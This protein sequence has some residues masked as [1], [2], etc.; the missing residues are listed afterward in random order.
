MAASQGSSLAPQDAADGSGTFWLASTAIASFIALFLYVT[1]T[2]TSKAS[3]ALRDPIPHVFNTLQFMFNNHKFMQRVQVALQ[4]RNLVCFFLGPKTVYLLSGPQAVKAMFS[5]ELVHKVTNQEQ[6]TRYALPTLYKM[7]SQEVQRWEDDKSGVTK[8]P[9]RGTEDTPTR[10]RLWYMYEHIYSEY[11]GRPQYMKPLVKMFSRNLSRALE[12]YPTGEWTT[13]SVRKI[14][15]HEVTESA[16]SALLG[17]D[18]IESSPDFV[19]RFWEFDKHVFALVLG[20]PKWINS[21][22]AKAHDLC[23]NAVQKW[24][25]SA[26]D[27]FDWDSPEAEEAWEP[28][29][30]GRA[31][32]ELVK[33]MKETEWRSEVIAATAGALIF[34]LNSN[35]IPTTIWMLMEII[36]DPSL[37]QALREEVETAMVTDPDTGKRTLDGQKIVT[38]PLLQSI[39]TETLRLRISFNIMRDVKQPVTIDGHTI[40]QGSLLQA[41]MQVAHCNEAVWGVAGH[42]AAEFW[43]ERHIKYVDDTS[44]S[45]QSSRKRMYATAGTPTAYFPFGGGVNICPGRQYAKAEI[46]TTIGLM[47]SQVDIEP[48]CWTELDGSPSNRAAKAD[49]R[50]CGSDAMP[51]DRDMKIRWRR[52]V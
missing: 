41:P 4:D 37:L 28:R 15:R 22:P 31:V 24:L 43:A 8:V 12:Q 40:A 50:Y 42:P 16:I 47:I 19:D 1:Q 13:V 26:S 29:F 36:K 46:L 33:W 48:V 51:P 7:N 49:P 2:Q 45:G 32:R 6:M 10:Q 9:I 20:L 38:L 18:L 23:V 14:C 25:E 35:S 21:K 3:H 27:N 52:I 17:P 34:A 44:A 11:L 39:F 30:G 5:R